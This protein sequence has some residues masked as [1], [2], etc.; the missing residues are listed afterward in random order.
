MYETVCAPTVSLE[1][2]RVGM[3]LGQVC[4]MPALVYCSFEGHVELIPGEPHP[5]FISDPVLCQLDGAPVPVCG[6]GEFCS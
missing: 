3:R 5:L 2:M 4:W 1:F 6:P